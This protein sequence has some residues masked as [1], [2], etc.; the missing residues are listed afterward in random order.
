M[1]QVFGEIFVLRD[2]LCHGTGGIHFSGLYAAL[3]IAPANLHQTAAGET[4]ERDAACDS[5]IHD[6]TCAGPEPQFFIQFA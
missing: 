1:Q 3:L 6:R 2:G 4:A 5:G